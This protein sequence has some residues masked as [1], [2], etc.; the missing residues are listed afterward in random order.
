MNAG[1]MTGFVGEVMPAAWR[2]AAKLPNVVPATT[3]PGRAQPQ[4]FERRGTRA[5]QLSN[6]VDDGVKAHQAATLSSVVVVS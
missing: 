4:R 1:I 6:V 2:A 5:E 3:V